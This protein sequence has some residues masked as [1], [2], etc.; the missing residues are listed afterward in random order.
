MIRRA[1]SPVLLVDGRKF[2]GRGASVLAHVSEMSLVITTEA[3][4]SDV[5]SLLDLGVEVHNV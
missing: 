2:E 5:D 1:E 4:Q 3:H